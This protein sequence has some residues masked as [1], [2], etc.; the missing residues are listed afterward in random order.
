VP[1]GNPA[2]GD[3]NGDITQLYRIATITIDLAHATGAAG[4]R[5]T[6]VIQH[7]AVSAQHHVVAALTIDGHAPATVA[8]ND[9]ALKVSTID[10]S[11]VVASL[12]T[13]AA[14]ASATTN[15]TGPGTNLPRC[16]K[17]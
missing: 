17:D 5:S 8:A 13:Y 15:A 14:S 4:Y 9:L 1:D 10:E 6:H 11:D 2:L 12:K 7:R 3:H 16:W